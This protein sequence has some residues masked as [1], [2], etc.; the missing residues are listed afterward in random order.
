MKRCLWCNGYHW[1]KWTWWP[2]FKSWTR[3]FA[4]HVTL[5]FL[6]KVWIKLFSLHLWEKRRADRCGYQFKRKNLN[7]VLKNWCCVVSCSCR[8]VGKYIYAIY[9]LKRC[10]LWWVNIVVKLLLKWLL[11]IGNSWY[12]VGYL[13]TFPFTKF[14]YCP[15]QSIITT[16]P[17]CPS[18]ILQYH[19][20]LLVFYHIIGMPDQDA[21]S[22]YNPLLYFQLSN[23]KALIQW[24]KI[25]I[26]SVAC[27]WH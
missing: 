7:S 5:I 19:Q 13:V 23:N 17:E 10:I 4:F 22:S 14:Q 27:I 6:G 24:C 9:I 20:T 26:D 12:S 2:N 15:G 21:S 18:S 1:R 11:F 25:L 16:N 8:G 3:L